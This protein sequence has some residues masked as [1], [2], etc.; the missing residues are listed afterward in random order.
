MV[1]VLPERLVYPVT[2]SR[3]FSVYFWALALTGGGAG[4]ALSGL[5]SYLHQNLLPF[6]DPASLMFIPQGITMLLYGT[7]AILAALYQWLTIVWDVGGGYNEFDQRT[8]TATIVRYGYPGKNRLVKLTY[9]FS[10]IV[11]LRV[12]IKEGL[13]PKR[14][15]YLRVK[16]RGEIPLTRV[17]QPLALAELENQ[18]A[19]LARFLN[20]TLEGI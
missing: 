10:E 17:G 8:A 15:V 6:S 1:T 12:E 3:R 13:N 9:A 2:G 16:G 11:G 18:A 7:A 4:F 14:A 5:S 19:E 20:V